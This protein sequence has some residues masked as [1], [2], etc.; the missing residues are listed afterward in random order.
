[1]SSR[2]GRL[3]RAGSRSSAPGSSGRQRPIG[4]ER[5]QRRLTL[6]V[7]NPPRGVKQVIINDLPDARQIDRLPR[8]RARTAWRRHVPGFDAMIIYV[9]MQPHLDSKPGSTVY[10]LVLPYRGKWEEVEALPSPLE[11]F[12]VFPR[13]TER[14]DWS[15][16]TMPLLMCAIPP[17]FP[18]LLPHQH[19]HAH[20]LS[21]AAL[22]LAGRTWAPRRLCRMRTCSSC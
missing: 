2:T 10:A 16:L 15:N 9:T 17:M 6:A 8:R 19:A 11:G 7:S 14:V 1:M 21:A 3:D 22:S 12:G 5:E 18:S 4:G 20:P 13:N